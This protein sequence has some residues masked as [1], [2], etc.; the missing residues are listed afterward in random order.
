MPY[1]KRPLIHSRIAEP[2]T[3]DSPTLGQ[4]AESS[5]KKS[6]SLR[7]RVEKSRRS[8]PSS[9]IER[10]AEQTRWP[11]K[12]DYFD[13]DT[14]FRDLNN[15]RLSQASTNSTVVEAMVIESPPRRRQTLRHTVKMEDMNSSTPPPPSNRNSL[16]SNERSSL[17][18]RLRRSVSPDQ[19]LRKS[20]ASADT[21]ESV[22]SNPSKPRQDPAPAIALPDQLS[23]IQSSTPGSKHLSRT[24]SLNARQQS[25]RP[26]TAPEESLSYFDVP[27]RRD[28]RTMSVVIQE[29]LKGEMRPPPSRS[30]RRLRYRQVVRSRGQ[31]L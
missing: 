28:R 29:S 5:F 23:T 8:L 13:V 26:T 1:D 9:S 11:L 3:L 17:R 2:P 10:S 21:P 27:P 20:F 15:K 18:R 4:E 7:Q 24:F 22:G 19:E 14:E 31:H 16:N 25:S 30:S 12:E 6:L